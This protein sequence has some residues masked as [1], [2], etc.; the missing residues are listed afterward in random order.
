MGSAWDL[1]WGLE[2]GE[3][4]RGRGR[5]TEVELPVGMMCIWDPW[6]SPASVAGIPAWEG[7]QI[8]PR[9]PRLT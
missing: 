4:L 6:H 7:G 2:L 8:D 1:G 3:T 9:S 5:D